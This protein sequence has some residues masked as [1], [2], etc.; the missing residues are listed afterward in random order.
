MI[1]EEDSLGGGGGSKHLVITVIVI[2]GISVTKRIKWD[3]D[4]R[5]YHRITLFSSLYLSA[6][7]NFDFT[8]QGD[9]LL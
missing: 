8:F 2:V 7:L 6:A 4:R 1:M 5:V 3:S 9:W